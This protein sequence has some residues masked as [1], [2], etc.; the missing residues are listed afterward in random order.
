MLVTTAYRPS[1]AEVERAKSLAAELGAR[2]VPRGDDSLPRLRRK[3][4][5]E[6]C[7]VVTASSLR[8]ERDR[9]PPLSFHPGMASIRIKRLL[10]GQG[11]PL[12]SACQAEPGDSVLD[13]T[14]GMGADALVFAHAVGGSGRVTALE[15]EKIIALILREGLR[16][17]ES[18][19]PALNAA[20]RR[21]R[22]VHAEHGEFLR[23][24]PSRSVDIVYFDPMFRTP[25]EGSHT[26]QV[27]REAAANT[28]PLQKEAVREAVRVARKCVVMK[29][30]PGS[31]EFARLGFT[32]PGGRRSTHAYGVIRI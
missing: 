31:G 5:D 21:I 8:Y 7:L 19:E 10:A 32:V 16:T 3:Y 28:A 1:A 30:R 4:G 23:R 20:M 13:C 14:A 26:L 15:S 24:M 27:L 9:V 25:V 18:D 17:Y 2:W 11:D 29:E 22:V 6:E 12:I